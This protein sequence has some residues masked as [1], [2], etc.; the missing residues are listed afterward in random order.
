ML[1]HDF[2]DELIQQGIELARTKN[3]ETYS[4]YSHFAVSAAL[5]LNDRGL[6]VPGVNI[7][8]RSFG[9]TMC[10]ERSAVASAISNFGSRDFGF[11]VLYTEHEPLT[12]PCGIC[13]QVLAEFCGPDFPIIMVNHKEQRRDLSFKELFPLPFDEF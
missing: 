11:L 1:V 10:A 3:G 6:F 8:N 9:G 5:Y 2:S 4:P 12:P 7:E 13:R